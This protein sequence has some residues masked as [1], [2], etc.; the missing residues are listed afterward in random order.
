MS[1]LHQLFEEYKIDTS[2]QVQYTTVQQ[3]EA[4]LASIESA[5]QQALSDY[6][7]ICI[8]VQAHTDSN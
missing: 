8:Q 4:E 3:I 5:R 1:M 7:D 2:V 6:H